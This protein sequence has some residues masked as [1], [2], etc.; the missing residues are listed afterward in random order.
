[1]ELNSSDQAAYSSSAL[2]IG[3]Y[4]IT[5]AYSGDVDFTAS[6]SPTLTETIVTPGTFTLSSSSGS[7]TISAGGT[8]T[9][10]IAVTPSGT[11]SNPITFTATG[12]PPGATATFSPSSLSL[13]T[14]AASTTLT[15]QTVA[16][17]AAAN[18]HG[19]PGSEAPLMA[20]AA[21]LLMLPL[22][23]IRA[24]RRRLGRLSNGL[25]VLLFLACSLSALAGLSGCGGKSGSGSTTPQVYTVTVTGTSG[26]LVQT[27][28]VTLTVQ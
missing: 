25:A 13:G 20:F 12:L 18:H 16:Q 8:A 5:A 14:S 17:T 15:I 4:S 6:I 19:K 22:F 9:Y 28:N 1:V 3:S 7:Q 2:A 26:S 23:R 11:V 24:V 21:G 10:V 27:T